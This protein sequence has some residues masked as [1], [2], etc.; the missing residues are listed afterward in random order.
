MRVE[1]CGTNK[2]GSNMKRTS[3]IVLMMTLLAGVSA[4]GSNTVNNDAAAEN[5]AATEAMANEMMADPSNPFA[6]VETQMSEAMMNAVG[7]DAGDTFLR[8]MIVH[9][10]G[11]INMS[12]IALKQDLPEGVAKMARDAIA[13]QSKEIADLK[14]F[15]QQGNPNP[16]SAEIYRPAKTEM[17]QAMM[18]AK[19]ANIAE[20]FMR[21]MLAH[22]EGGAALADVALD[23]GV[24]GALRAQIEKTHN[25]QHEDAEMVEAMLSGKSMQHASANA[26]APACNSPAAPASK[27][28]PVPGTHTPEHDAHEMN[29][30]NHM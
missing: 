24:S 11:A 25:G 21:K 1:R 6:G 22:H 2:E 7:S 4:C 19:G 23:S 14:K 13:K 26:N 17:H 8:K 29:N 18:N 27:G 15:V 16:K 30:M 9:H 12:Q 20:T 28:M 5:M 3:K 10:Q